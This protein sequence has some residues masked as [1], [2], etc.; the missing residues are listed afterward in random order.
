M[1]VFHPAVFANGQTLATGLKFLVARIGL[2]AGFQALGRGLVR[3]RHGAVP[4]H[5]FLDL[6]VAVLRYSIESKQ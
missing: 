5:V 2:L 1:L 4:G 3:G 6:L